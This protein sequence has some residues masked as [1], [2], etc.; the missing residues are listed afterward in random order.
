VLAIG[1]VLL[2]I[3]V[4]DKAD[5]SVTCGSKVMH[6]GEVCEKSGHS[7][8]FEHQQADERSTA[9]NSVIGGALVTL[10][11]LGLA[12]FSFRQR[13]TSPRTPTAGIESTI[14]P[15][16]AS[17]PPPPDPSRWPPVGHD[18]A[19]TDVAVSTTVPTTAELV[20]RYATA[21]NANFATEHGVTSPLGVW[22]L[23]ALAAPAATGAARERLEQIVG[24]VA[25]EASARAQALLDEPHQAV[26]VA[27]AVWARARILND[28][29]AA[30]AA[31][32]P[33]AVEQGDVPTQ[34]DADMWAS[35]H[36]G[37]MID[38]FP[39]TVTP[40]TALLLATAVA[41]DISWHVPFRI[42]PAAGLG[43]EFGPRINTA[44]V[45]PD[46]HNQFLAL[47]ASAGPVAVHVAASASGLNVISVLAADSVPPAGVHAAAHEIAALLAGTGRAA[48]RMSLFTV[49]VGDGPAWTLTETVEESFGGP[50]RRE[51]FSTTMAAWSADSDH[52][53]ISAA[54]FAELCE[55]FP[56]FVRDEFLP[57]SFSARQAAVASYTR[58]G[59]K[60]AAVTAFGMAFGSAPSPR[61][62]TVV[63]RHAAI[64]FNRP[65]A[66]LAV[67]VTAGNS[68]DERKK[69]DFGG[70]A[71]A[72]VPVFSA[73]VTMPRDTDGNASATGN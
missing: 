3:G 67:A 52:D 20:A 65:Y 21:F 35:S 68:M 1:L 34:A 59:F 30:F 46:E 25:G 58:V 39:V 4:A 9:R 37:G 40:D 29:F 16:R 51:T 10:G 19:M 28:R 26:A 27:A 56:E 54:G 22:I 17:A 33:T 2:A 55:T 63:H 13:R 11:G 45:A 31:G 12:V 36:T 50:S 47:T 7:T 48:T 70:S 24:C 62:V 5:D 69:V 72:N 60:A 23:L 66:V 44:L 61:K 15:G 64:R 49:E 18:T 14:E 53:I 38:T 32:F 8:S 6:T 73:W 43:G 42:A 41:T 71:W 57:V